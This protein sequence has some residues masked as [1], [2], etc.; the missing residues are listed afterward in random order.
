M[1]LGLFNLGHFLLAFLYHEVKGL[2]VKES[3]GKEVVAVSLNIKP[4]EPSI[5]VGLVRPDKP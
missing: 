3:N 5:M 2:L 4:E 1:A